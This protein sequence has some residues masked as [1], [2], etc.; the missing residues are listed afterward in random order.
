[1]PSVWRLSTGAFGR[2]SLR[3]AEVC[4]SVLP[5]KHRPVIVLQIDS[6]CIQF[7][8]DSRL[9][10]LSQL[11]LRTDGERGSPLLIAMM[12]QEEHHAGRRPQFGQVACNRALTQLRPAS[13]YTDRD[14]RVPDAMPASS[15]PQELV[16]SAPASAGAGPQSCRDVA[17]APA[18]EGAAQRACC[19]MPCPPASVRMAGML[20][21]AAPRKRTGRCANQI[22]NAEHGPSRDRRSTSAFALV[23]IEAQRLNQVAA[24]DQQVGRLADQV[25][26][27]RTGCSVGR[28]GARAV[29]VVPSKAG[30]NGADTEPGTFIGQDDHPASQACGRRGVT[31]AAAMLVYSA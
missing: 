10:H 25:A 27:H 31:G 21:L 7:I 1:M 2:C 24:V 5:R 30:I 19:Q 18:P 13:P 15:E 12:S 28:R 16:N 23:E 3:W 17:T 6:T 26:E 8:S 29:Q 22:G 14:L 11:R 9:L 4:C 20:A